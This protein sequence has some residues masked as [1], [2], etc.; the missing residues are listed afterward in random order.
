[1]DSRSRQKLQDGAIVLGLLETS[2]NTGSIWDYLLFYAI[3][4]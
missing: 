1:M 4:L 3:P 2:Q